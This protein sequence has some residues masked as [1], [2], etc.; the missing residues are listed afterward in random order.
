M[1]SSQRS[2]WSVRNLALTLAA[3]ATL[4]SIAAVTPAA[5]DHEEPADSVT[6]VGSFQTEVGCP[7]NWAPE[8]DA[9]AM[10]F[11]DGV[12]SITVEVPAGEWEWKVAL[13]DSWARSYPTAG[14]VLLTLAGPSG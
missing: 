9:T 1:W 11:V 12:G 4:A 14:N 8:C 5:A 6:L 10:E 13:D 3:A 7:A 2:G